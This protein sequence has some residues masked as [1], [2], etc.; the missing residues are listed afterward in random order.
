MFVF[1]LYVATSVYAL[2]VNSANSSQ[3]IHLVS[4]ASCTSSGGHSHCQAVP[5]LH[6]SRSGNVHYHLYLPCICSVWPQFDLQRHLVISNAIAV[7]LHPVHKKALTASLR[8]FL[9]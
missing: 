5:L 2:D 1:I 9:D 3:S 7:V 8:V 4:C 6:E